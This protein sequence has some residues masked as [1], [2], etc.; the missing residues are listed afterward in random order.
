MV[1]DEFLMFMQFLDYLIGF[2]EENAENIVF[3][4]MD[5][6]YPIFHHFLTEFWKTA[7]F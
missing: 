6:W 2:L 1:K 4:L 3:Q 5:N 7:E